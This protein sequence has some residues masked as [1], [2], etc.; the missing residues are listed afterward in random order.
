MDRETRETID[1]YTNIEIAS[2]G[3]VDYNG[4]ACGV[5]ADGRETPPAGTLVDPV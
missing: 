5:P 3:M 4:K 1:G 2:L